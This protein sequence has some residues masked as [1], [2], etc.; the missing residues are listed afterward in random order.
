LGEFEMR[1]IAIT[2]LLFATAVQ[3][4][5][6]R[7]SYVGADA[8]TFVG[9]NELGEPIAVP[10]D[11]QLSGWFEVFGGLA[12]NLDQVNIGASGAGLVTDWA[13]SP[14]LDVLGEPMP[15]NPD[16]TF[17]EYPVVDGS[18]LTLLV[19]TDA[20]GEIT[21]WSYVA[22]VA[23]IDLASFGDSDSYAYSSLYFDGNPNNGDKRYFSEDFWN[24]CCTEE[25]Y[26]SD[27]VGTWSSAA[28]PVPA[29]VWL[30]GSGL[31]LLGWLRRRQTA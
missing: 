16:L 4:E 12:A 30:F 15:I 19:S 1:L 7:Y 21:E 24:S 10:A 28:V 5:T 31:G 18:N 2:I 20:L 23:L 17:P 6:I 25:N 11:F 26:I 3:A 14:D 13:F 8:S 29:A 27:S 9:E 22:S